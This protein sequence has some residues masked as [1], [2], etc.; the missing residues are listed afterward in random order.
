L[1]TVFI[2]LSDMCAPLKHFPYSIVGTTVADIPWPQG[3][4]QFSQPAHSAIDTLLTLDPVQRPAAPQVKQMSLFSAI[5]WDNL[6]ST[7]APFVPQP[8]DSTDTVYF[9]GMCFSYAAK[10]GLCHTAGH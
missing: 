8:D 6:L 9:Q 4:E 10:S 7:T 2:E 1:E 3:K 5:D